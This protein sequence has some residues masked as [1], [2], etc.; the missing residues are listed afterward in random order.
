MPPSKNLRSYDHITRVFEAALLQDGASYQLK[1]DFDEQGLAIPQSA[2]KKAF[3]WRRDANYLRTLLRR[4][5]PLNRCKYDC[6]RILLRGDTVLLEKQVEDSGTLL[7]KDG[8]PIELPA[9]E[10]TEPVQLDVGERLNLAL[11]MLEEK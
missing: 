1:P 8:K 6:F 10:E 9:I 7:D 5:D 3:V 4:N 2:E 11:G